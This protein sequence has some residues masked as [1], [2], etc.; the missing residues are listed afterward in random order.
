MNQS[1]IGILNGSKFLIFHIFRQI[2]TQITLLIEIWNGTIKT[3]NAIS[4]I[5]HQPNL[6]YVHE[7]EINI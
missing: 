1:K 4:I 5:S 7:Y 3:S 6:T 2:K